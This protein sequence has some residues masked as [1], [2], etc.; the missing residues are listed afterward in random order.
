MQAYFDEMEKLALSKELLARAATAAKNDARALG[1]TLVSGR[2]GPLEVT[3]RRLNR[4]IDRRR[5]Q[6]AKFTGKSPGPSNAP[7]SAAETS[8]LVREAR[9]HPFYGSGVAGF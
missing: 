4:V 3:G 2:I 9:K 6:L 7:A 5:R 8:P 1:Q